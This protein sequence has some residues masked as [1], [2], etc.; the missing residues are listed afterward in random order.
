MDVGAYSHSL[1]P[2]GIN[3]AANL[4]ALIIES[5]LKGNVILNPIQLTYFL[6]F[7]YILCLNLNIVVSIAA[8]ESAFS[9]DEYDYLQASIYGKLLTEPIFSKFCIFM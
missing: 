1:P 9:E 6:S 2:E 7:I 8:S 3:A 4:F 5:E